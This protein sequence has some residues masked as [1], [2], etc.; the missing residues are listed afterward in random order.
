[1]A[2]RRLVSFSLLAALSVLGCYAVAA[3]ASES[4]GATL[5]GRTWQLSR[6]AG[7]DRSGAGITATFTS[8][9]KLSG[10][11]GCNSYRGSYTTSGD[12]IRVSNKLAVT[13]MACGNSLMRMESSYLEALTSATTY[14]VQNA[15]LTLM[16]RKNR[17][18]A[19][20]SVQSQSLAGTTWRVLYYNNGKQDVVSV[21]AQTKLTATFARS[22]VSGFAGCNDYR[23]AFKTNP[24]QISI[25]A[26]SST[27]KYCGDP[28]G[29][30]EQESKYLAALESA[31][32][33]DSYGHTLEF[34]TSSGALA[35]IL[36]RS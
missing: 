23:G 28:P 25:G 27:K 29:V 33:Y 2:F 3:R 36:L 6:L 17:E 1:M 26:L 32:T 12:S 8:A 5:T 9:G 20:F 16:G 7:A 11:S 19:T 10:F 31:A 24:R 30:M 15:T 13:L 18:L 34:R 14:T 35:V 21:M 22:D 4:A